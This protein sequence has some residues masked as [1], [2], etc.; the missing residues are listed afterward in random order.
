MATEAPQ[1]KVEDV[2]EFVHRSIEIR[3]YEAEVS[4]KIKRPLNAFMLYRKA[5]QNVA[6]TQ[7]TRNNHQH[8]SSICGESWSS[9]EPPD[10]VDKFNELAAIERRM[11]E[12]AFPD[13]RYDPV[14]AKSHT[15]DLAGRSSDRRPVSVHRASSRNTTPKKPV[16]YSANNATWSSQVSHPAAPSWVGRGS[17]PSQSQTLFDLPVAPASHLPT[18]PFDMNAACTSSL[19][20][21]YYPELVVDP[22]F[23]SYSQVP[24][25]YPGLEPAMALPTN[26]QTWDMFPH[27]FG[28]SIPD[29]D[30]YGGHNQYLRGT[31]ADWEVEKLPLRSDSDST[32]KGT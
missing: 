4:G 26:W 24:A 18:T 10:I 14:L 5:F 17:V 32:R 29:L 20:G 8:I 27:Q 13:Y 3:R 25:A 16:G 28:D 6:K 15:A 9:Q 31:D 11:H 30:I 19:H 21:S 12:Q 1:I 2:S 22:S 23:L 7:S